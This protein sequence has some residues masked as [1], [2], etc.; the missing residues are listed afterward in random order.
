[1]V[2]DTT[3]EN[4]GEDADVRQPDTREDGPNAPQ[5]Q[6]EKIEIY[7]VTEN[8]VTYIISPE[9]T[10]Q[11][12]NWKLNAYGSAQGPLKFP[13]GISDDQAEYLGL[14]PETQQTLNED[15]QEVREKGDLPP[16]FRTQTRE[17]R[18]LKELDENVASWGEE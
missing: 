3:P 15:L 4:E 8:G 12:T 13:N 17:R 11:G 16:I 1:M 18:S 10:N 5:K 7:T 2:P 14:S 6:R 9:I